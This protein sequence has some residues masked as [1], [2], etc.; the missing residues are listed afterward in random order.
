MDFHTAGACRGLRKKKCYMSSVCIMVESVLWYYY[1]LFLWV[2]LLI[3]MF[4]W[5]LFFGQI[6]C[7]ASSVFLRL[8][9][10]TCCAYLLCMFCLVRWCASRISILSFGC[11]VFSFWTLGFMCEALLNSS[12]RFGGINTQNSHDTFEST[13]KLLNSSF[14]LCDF[15]MCVPTHWFLVVR[16]GVLCVRYLGVFYVYFNLFLFF[17]FCV[18]LIICF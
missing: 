9:D 12:A 6:L 7:V 18:N 4:C 10:F 5:V 15:I 13:K 17:L 16:R 3:L 1:S 14:L 8:K 2:F 11:C